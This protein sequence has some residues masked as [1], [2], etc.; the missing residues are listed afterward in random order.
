MTDILRAEWRT[1]S[2]VCNCLEKNPV[3]RLCEFLFLA[4]ER[5]T[6]GLKD[7]TDWLILHLCPIPLRTG[8]AQLSLSVRRMVSPLYSQRISV[9][10][11]SFCFSSILATAS[12]GLPLCWGV[13][14]TSQ[15]S[16]PV[17]DLRVSV[18]F[19]TQH[20]RYFIQCH[21][22]GIVNYSPHGRLIFTVTQIIGISFRRKEW[23]I[24]LTPSLPLV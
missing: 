1:A 2:L 10:N 6:L 20:G 19:A 13:V 4:A 22:A 5:K 14:R 21:K 7:P 8:L 24:I 23:D 18:E 15:E 12:R 11:I 9:S 17:W 3:S 16:E